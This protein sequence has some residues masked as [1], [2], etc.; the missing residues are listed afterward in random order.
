MRPLEMD[1][2][3][4]W[5]LGFIFLCSVWRWC[6]GKLKDADGFWAGPRWLPACF[7]MRLFSWGLPWGFLG[8][9]YVE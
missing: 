2:P 8:A 9:V 5:S 7:V 3:Q 1:K 6:V 4:F